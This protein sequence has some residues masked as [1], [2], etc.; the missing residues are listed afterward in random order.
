MTGF[1]G[2]LPESTDR[3]SHHYE[4]FRSSADFGIPSGRQDP[5]GVCTFIYNSS[6][7]SNGTFTTPNYP[8]VYPRDTECHYLFYGKDKEKIHI[9]VWCLWTSTRSEA[10][11][12]SVSSLSLYWP[13]RALTFCSIPST[14]VC[15]LRRRRRAAL[16]LGHGLRLC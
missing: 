13:I 10:F 1:K 6:E 9:Q 5:Q 8:G 14:V 15:L 2:G 11:L 3:L 4:F 16:H 7:V 12:L